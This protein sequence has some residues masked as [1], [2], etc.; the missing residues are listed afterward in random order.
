M[1]SERRI[2]V[3]GGLAALSGMERMQAEPGKIDLQVL[4]RGD[5]RAVDR[6]RLWPEALGVRLFFS[7]AESPQRPGGR[8]VTVVSSMPIAPDGKSSENLRVNHLLPGAA[9]WDV[10]GMEGSNYAV[11][12]GDFGGAVSSLGLYRGGAQTALTEF[13]SP[14]DFKD[15]RFSRGERRPPAV[16]S[17]VD[18][19]R[20]AVLPPSGGDQ[21]APPR[22]AVTKER[23]DSALMIAAP[24]GAWLLFKQYAIG[25]KRSR[26]PGILQAVRL[27][28]GYAAAGAVF[29]PMG[30]R[31]VFE[32]DADV[33]EDGIAIVATSKDGF[34][35]G[36]GKLETITPLEY[37]HGAELLQPAL[38]QTGQGIQLAF[39]ESPGSDFQHIVTAS[40]AA[41][42]LRSR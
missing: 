41:A 18:G 37:K 33:F 39:L 16:T 38:V 25:P 30:D 5:T 27:D 7:H 11:V 28:G 4:R 3:F 6:I 36:A 12:M 31:T 35:L 19:N 26:F 10:T 24:G 40:V 29:R 9:E 15:P 22:M 8:H 21:Y 17:V 2:L 32:F 20:V 14:D 42:A 23:L 34:L 1:N 13:T